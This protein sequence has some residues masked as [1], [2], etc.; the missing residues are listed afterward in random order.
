MF[1]GVLSGQTLTLRVAPSDPSL[2]PASYALQ[3]TNGTGKCSVPC[4]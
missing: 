1:S 4:V 3:L 2:R